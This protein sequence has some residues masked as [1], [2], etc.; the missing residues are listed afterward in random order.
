[1]SEFGD[2]AIYV[3]GK[4]EGLQKEEVWAR[5]LAAGAWGQN[6]KSA[7][8]YLAADPADPKLIATGKPI[9]TLA[10]LPQ[11]LDG[12]LAQLK[13]AVAHR[14]AAIKTYPTVDA[15]AHLAY[16]PPADDALIATIERAVGPLPADLLSLMRQFNGLSCV[17][18]LMEKGHGIT[19]PSD[20]P[21]PYAALAHDAH[22]LWAG[23]LSHLDVTIALPTW[24][25]IFLR[26]QEDRICN[27]TGHDPRDALKIGALKVKAGELYPCLFA[28]DLFHHYAGAALYLDPKEG[29]A[30]LLYGFDCWADLTSAHPTSLRFYME[31]LV[32]AV[33]SRMSFAG[34][35]PIK[36]TSKTAWPTYIRNIHNA[37]W[38]Y[39]ELK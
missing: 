15:V 17:V 25:D 37:P 5:L 2:K 36:P 12:W 38:V 26:A 21:L 16:G 27:H 9:Y 23:R 4:F 3:S 30:K 13:A 31:S 6:T 33:W 8:A 20:A 34:P 1:M 24:E 29:D 10:D 11:S 32:A 35:R 14:G 7:Q 28:F 18:G 39:I 22:P 19:L